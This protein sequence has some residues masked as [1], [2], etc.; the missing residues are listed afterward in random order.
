MFFRT[1]LTAGA[2]GLLS[3][4]S[5]AGCGIDSGSVRIG[6]KSSPKFLNVIFHQ[7][8]DESTNGW[9]GAAIYAEAEA[10]LNVDQC[11]F[12]DNK[13]TNLD[14]CLLYTSPSPRDL[15]T[16]RMPSSA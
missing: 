10:V 14:G 11:Q 2:I 8:I 15:S 5:Y 1:I 16:S 6:G 13:T 7:N 12:I 3:T 9:T 4:A